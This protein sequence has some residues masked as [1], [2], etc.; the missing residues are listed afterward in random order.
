ML[1]A[2]LLAGCGVGLPEDGEHEDAALTRPQGDEGTSTLS[3]FILDVGQGDASLLLAGDGEAALIDAGPPGAGSAVIRPMLK[4]LGIERLAWALV[5]HHHADHEGGLAE[6]IAGEDGI[7][8]TGD[9]LCIEGGI[10]GRDGEVGDTS[11]DPIPDACGCAPGCDQRT[12]AAG[13][14]LELGDGDLQVVA[15]GGR[16]ADGTEVDVSPSQPGED[17]DENA[18]SVALLLRRAG[19]TMLFAGDITGGGGEEPYQT[20]DIETLL[21]PLIGELDVLRVSHHGSDTSSNAAFL[22]ATHPE[23][24]IISVG[25]GNDYGHPSPAVIERLEEAGS[26]VL[27]TENGALEDPALPPA[28]NTIRIDIDAEGAA[29]IR[30][31]F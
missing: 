6:L 5:T 4:R 16:L 30:E 22:Q 14:H 26:R 3:V 23:V 17:P 7:A 31:K 18:L 15:S 21:A 13:D 12:A 24:A 11:G 28:G 1:I 29:T 2:L 10:Y 27:R 9:D 25:D 20:P 19:F 8:G